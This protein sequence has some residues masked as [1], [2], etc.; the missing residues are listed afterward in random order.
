MYVDI[1]ESTQAANYPDNVNDFGVISKKD[2][3]ADLDN[4]GKIDDTDEKG[5]NLILAG[6]EFS[7]PNDGTTTYS[8]YDI[9]TVP[10]TGE[11]RQGGTVLM[12]KVQNS[13]KEMT[14]PLSIS[15]CN[16]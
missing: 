14:A 5:L 16:I 3:D 13:E 7:A 2:V 1:D 10:P 4:D 6:L 11:S 15:A 8:Q 12:T 9:A